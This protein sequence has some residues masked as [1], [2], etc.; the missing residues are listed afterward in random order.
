V[1]SSVPV[2]QFCEVGNVAASNTRAADLLFDI[3]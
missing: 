1:P 2:I 3:S